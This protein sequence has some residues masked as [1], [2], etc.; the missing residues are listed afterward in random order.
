M[1]N[2]DCD[3]KAPPPLNTRP[4]DLYQAIES[5]TSIHDSL[6]A[7]IDRITGESS[8]CDPTADC[9]PDIRLLQI[10]EQAPNTIRNRVDNAHDKI[11]VLNR[12]LFER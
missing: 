6:D 12:L 7:L 4:E 3:M 11:N 8:P 9:A 2:T 1:S 10:L 5:M